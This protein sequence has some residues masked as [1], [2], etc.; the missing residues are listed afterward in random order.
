MSAETT[1]SREGRMTCEQVMKENLVEK[2][3]VGAL[4]A[5]EQ[6]TFEQHYFE[7]SR[8]FAELDQHRLLQ[9]ALQQAEAD[10]R[11]ETVAPRPLRNWQWA[12]AAVAAALILAVGLGI[13]QS[14]RREAAPTVATPSGPPSPGPQRTQPPAT[15]RPSLVELARFEPPPYT[16]IVLRGSSDAATQHFQEAMRRYSKGDYKEA[17][18]GLRQGAALNPRAADISFFLG[19][20]YLLTDQPDA[21][22]SSLRSTIAL[23]DSP[24][25]EDAHFYL[26][27]AYL[28]QG[29]L[30]AAQTELKRTIQLRGE[31]EADA[32][33]LLA[34]LG[35]LNR[36]AP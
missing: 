10:I 22:V 31:H 32:G 28:H 13:W 26:A 25:L 12:A 27:K 23:G 6:D 34:K 14:G 18:P 7:C 1:N 9:Q 17:I 3:L 19:I 5:P 4:S 29:E 15:Q 2:Y 16:P 35:H 36:A 20:C 11:R 30:T 24:F 21:A 8:C 33:V